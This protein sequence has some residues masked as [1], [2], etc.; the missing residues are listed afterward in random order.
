V[1]IA[2]LSSTARA[3][4]PD[5]EPQPEPTEP[6]AQPPPA[7][8][9]A[10]AAPAAPAAAA[11][12]PAQNPPAGGA[13][14]AAEPP[15]TPTLDFRGYVTPGFDLKA[16]PDATPRSRFEYGF[17]GTGGL[18]FDATP[19]NYWHARLE[20]EFGIQT[21]HF[22]ESIEQRDIDGDGVQEVS[23]TTQRTVTLGIAS[24]LDATVMFRPHEAFGVKGGVFR[25]PFTLSQ[26]SPQ[27][28]KMFLTRAPP[29]EVFISGSD[30]GAM[31]L[32]RLSSGRVEASAGVFNGRSL[33]L[34]LAGLD[35]TGPLLSFRADVNP[36]GDF[37]A[38]EG[39]PQ[40]GPFRLG[41]GFGLL[42]RPSTLYDT[43]SGLEAATAHDVRTCASLRLAVAG[44]YVGVEYLHSQQ[45]DSISSRPRIA[46]G[47]YVQASFF[48]PVTRTVA[49]A[50]VGRL[51]IT[52][53]DQAFA[54]RTIGWTDLGLALYPRAD[55]P[56]PD[57]LKIT[58]SYVGER[59]FTE[60]EDAHGASLSG[61][62][63]F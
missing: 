1:A 32:T 8:E 53:E 24:V 29:S 34:P 20:L 59:R 48:V 58:L 11:A 10:G 43:A 9:P 16:R 13:A 12:E 57:T 40:R 47:G 39:D 15:E 56:Q 42:Y 2:L 6:E 19:L 18:S 45:T 50:P 37:P 31:L 54:P 44:L 25:I 21:I 33:G 51:G 52:A 49:I 14:P 5:P 26:Q 41:V 60:G 61:L 7:P 27:T 38:W 28:G 36:F 22:V 46:D 62:L 35:S 30:A 63:R 3:Q 4:P 17:A 55:A 23:R